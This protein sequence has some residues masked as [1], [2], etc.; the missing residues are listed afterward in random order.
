LDEQLIV[1]IG[2]ILDAQIKGYAGAG[3]DIPQHKG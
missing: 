3:L 2:L 1:G